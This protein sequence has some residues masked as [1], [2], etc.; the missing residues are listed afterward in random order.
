MSSGI[1]II[2]IGGKR[3]IEEAQT[4]L[5]AIRRISDLPIT[6][7]T[8]QPEA[9][10][11]RCSI[12]RS[13]EERATLNPPGTVQVCQ[14]EDLGGFKNQTHY[15]SHTPY[16]KTVHLDCDAIPVHETAFEPL[17]LLGRF[18]FAASLEFAR[19]LGAQREGIPAA[20]AQWNCGVM[21]FDRTM[22]SIFEAW[23]QPFTGWQ[24]NPQGPLAC[25]LWDRPDIRVCTL[26]PEWN[27]KGAGLCA[28]R[29]DP[30]AL[31]RIAHNHS[32]PDMID[33]DGRLDQR[34]FNEW[35]YARTISRLQQEWR[36]VVCPR[37]VR[38]ARVSVLGWLSRRPAADRKSDST[39][40]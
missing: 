27:Y 4:N 10:Q 12:Q 16:D 30:P 24:R 19:G 34:A 25:L 31:I 32:V 33:A 38:E 11:G 36:V 6:L 3:Y 14:R 39:R 5:R 9:F 2:S 26:A 28:S 13:L 21:F 7:Y 22:L 20:F 17:G 40:Q 23:N 35:F 37:I 18:H 15:V 1:L 29:P 8:N